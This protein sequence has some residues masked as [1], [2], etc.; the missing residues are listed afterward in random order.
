MINGSRISP[1]LRDTT[2]RSLEWRVQNGMLAEIA[3]A[4]DDIC[5]RYG[6][7]ETSTKR[8]EHEVAD[9]EDKPKGFL[10]GGIS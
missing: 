7:G 9:R 2:F 1:Y 3:K 6:V 8:A 4:T 10:F 5:K